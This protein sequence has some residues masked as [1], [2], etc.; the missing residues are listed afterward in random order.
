MSLLPEQREIAQAVGY[1]PLEGDDLTEQFQAPVTFPASPGQAPGRC[2]V[3]LHE[4]RLQLFWMPSTSCPS[5]VHTVSDWYDIPTN[6]EIEEWVFDSLCPTP[7]DDTVEP[8]HP[9][10]WLSLLGLV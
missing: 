2:A 9:D 3:R 1:K 4:G 10:S 5:L 7:D 6:E 8:D